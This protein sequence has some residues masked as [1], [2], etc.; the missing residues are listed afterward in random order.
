MRTKKHN[1]KQEVKNMPNR[2]GGGPV[3]GGTGRGRG[4]C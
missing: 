2:D 1:I 4:S 3:G